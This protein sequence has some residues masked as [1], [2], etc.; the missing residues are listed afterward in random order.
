MLEFQSA[1]EEENFGVQLLA[2]MCS[3]KNVLVSEYGLNRTGWTLRDAVGISADGHPMVGYGP[4]S[5]VRTEF[6]WRGTLVP[7][8]PN[9][10]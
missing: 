10:H 9:R 4:I 3:L 6:G 2:G 1:V 5:P 7:A 8:F